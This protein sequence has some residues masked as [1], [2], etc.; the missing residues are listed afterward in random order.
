MLLE[1]ICIERFLVA[2]IFGKKVAFKCNSKCVQVENTQQ[3]WLRVTVRQ[4]NHRTNFQRT[5]IK[6][7]WKAHIKE[8]IPDSVPD[9]SV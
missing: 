9:I 5:I 7:S 2:K 3:S 1:K 4:N 6:I 8:K